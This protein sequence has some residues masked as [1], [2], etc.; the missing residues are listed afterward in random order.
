MKLSSAVLG[1]LLTALS[2]RAAISEA[3]LQE[4]AGK[5]LRL[6]S[7]E[8][9]VDPV[10]KTEDEKLELMRAFVNFVSLYRTP[11]RTILRV[12]YPQFDV[13]EV[14][15]SNT[16]ISPGPAASFAPSV[17]C[18]FIFLAHCFEIY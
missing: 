2:V 8:D 13:T 14:Y 17:T 1:A 15:D 16:P 6:I 11:I 9:G 10:W 7:L 3:E 4:N 12:N 5:G 18:T